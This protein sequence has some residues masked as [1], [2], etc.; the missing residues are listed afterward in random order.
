MRLIRWQW[1]CSQLARELLS[2]GCGAFVSWLV[3]CSWLTQELWELACE[4]FSAGSGDCVQFARGWA[5]MDAVVGNCSNLSRKPQSAVHGIAA[6]WLGSSLARE[7][8]L[9]CACSQLFERCSQL[10]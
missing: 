1:S 3:G 8:Q 6:S 4:L 7:Q 5:A 2:Y 10:A 9:A